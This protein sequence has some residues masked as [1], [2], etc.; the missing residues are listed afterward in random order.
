MQTRKVKGR[1]DMKRNLGVV[2]KRMLMGALTCALGFS[3]I[4]LS[5]STA[6]A[7]EKS[8]PDVTDMAMVIDGGKTTYYDDLEKA[9]AYC[10]GKKDV[11]LQLVNDVP[12][13]GA[14]YIGDD[15][16]GVTLDMNG[17]ALIRTN[18]TSDFKDGEVI[19]IQSGADFHIINS[20]PDF[21]DPFTRVKGGCIYG[22]YSS[23]GGGGIHISDGGKLTME[24]VNICKNRSTYN[25]GGIHVKRGGQLFMKGGNFLQNRAQERKCHGA[26]IYNEGTVDCSGVRFDGNISDYSGGAIYHAGGRMALRSCTFTNNRAKDNGGAIAVD[27]EDIDIFDCV[28]EDN[29]AEDDGGGIWVNAYRCFLAGGRIRRNMADYGGGV[30]VDS[31]VDIG[32]Q[33]RL[34]IEGNKTTSD[35]DSDLVLQAGIAS[36]ALAYDGGLLPGSR[37]GLDKTKGLSGSG[38]RAVV[39]V[40]DYENDEGYFFAN[41]GRLKLKDLEGKQ[42][43]FMATAVDQYGWG[44]A[45]LIVLELVGGIYAVRVVMKRVKKGKSNQ[46]GGDRL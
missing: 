7:K 29:H 43:V 35:K 1:T 21:E 20:R 27:G 17:F 6:G 23:D 10:A 2:K 41:R 45:L 22:G 18:L 40:N 26:A 13:K 42:E 3:C 28:I 31:K 30:Y 9:F 11:T 5:A 4:F 37:I 36:R 25:G 46:A 44:I 38:T 12:V 32:I 24:N 8:A 15:M 16:N 39:N 33:G 19:W 14:K 34:V